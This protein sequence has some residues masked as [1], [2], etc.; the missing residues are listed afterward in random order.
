MPVRCY[1]NWSLTGE[2]YFSTTSA[3]LCQCLQNR[4]RIVLGMKHRLQCILLLRLCR[5]R[6]LIAYGKTEILYYI[7]LL[8]DW[9]KMSIAL[10]KV[11][12]VW[13]TVALIWFTLI[14]LT[15]R[16]I[17]QLFFY[18]TYSATNKSVHKDISVT[19]DSA[20]SDIFAIATQH[21]CTFFT[22]V[23]EDTGK[24]SSHFTTNNFNWNIH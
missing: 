20:F 18:G 12:T 17:S 21:F 2:L 11:T 4:C 16:F 19:V 3:I 23:N 22:I 7:S 15:C 8:F 13:W 5:K 1:E 24:N 14:L 10:K 9:V 6:R